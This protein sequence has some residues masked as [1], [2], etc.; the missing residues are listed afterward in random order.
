MKAGVFK[1][2]SARRN[3]CMYNA[4]KVTS[5]CREASR[6]DDCYTSIQ[7]RLEPLKPVRQ[8]A[9][10]EG[11]SLRPPPQQSRQPNSPKCKIQHSF[12]S[13]SM[14]GSRPVCLD[15]R[16]SNPGVA[17]RGLFNIQIQDVIS[18]IN[19]SRLN[20]TCVSELYSGGAVFIVPCN[21]HMNQRNT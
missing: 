10:C 6:R 16:S 3:G 13:A 7:L 12:N 1:N 11:F 14:T 19:G 21:M 20:R 17:W 15:I 9:G 8:S 18:K 4:S 2:T 5:L